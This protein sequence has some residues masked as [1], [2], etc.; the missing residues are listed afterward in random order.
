MAVVDEE[1]D[2]NEEDGDDNEEEEEG[3][4]EEEGYV[5]KMAEDHLGLLVALVAIA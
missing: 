3:D 4:G 1:D 5:P 2:R